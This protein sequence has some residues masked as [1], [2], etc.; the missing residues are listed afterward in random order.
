MLILDHRILGYMHIQKIPNT[1][2]YLR[3][4]LQFSEEV[5]DNQSGGYVE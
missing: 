2:Y 5:R 4:F 3:K 1:K